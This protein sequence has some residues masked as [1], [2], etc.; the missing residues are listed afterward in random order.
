[1]PADPAALL[2]ATP[3]LV[4]HGPFVLGA[5]R[6]DQSAAVHAATRR[7]E[8]QTTFVVVDDKE[9]T[10]LVL[11]SVFDEL[12]EPERLQ[13]GWALLTLDLTLG[14][15]VVGVLAL[16]TAALSGAGVPVGAVTAF[17]RDHLLVPRDRLDDARAALEG[18]CASFVERSP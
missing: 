6:H 14:W 18:L 10:A 15:D 5:W 3:V 7:A 13:R 16:L 1:M 8:R 4:D 12:P 2:R 17:S 11:E 9:V